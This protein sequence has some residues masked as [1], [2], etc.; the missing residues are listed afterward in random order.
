MKSIKQAN[1][2]LEKLNFPIIIRP[3]FTMGGTGG[4]IAYNK[5]EFESLIEKGLHSSPINEV[6]IESL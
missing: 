6:L 4:S 1:T 3:S 2:F 5:E